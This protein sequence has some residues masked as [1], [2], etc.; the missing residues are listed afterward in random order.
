VFGTLNVY[1]KRKKRRGRRA[2]R[3]GGLYS[4]LLSQETLV[5][6]F[7]IGHLGGLRDFGNLSVPEKNVLS[8]TVGKGFAFGA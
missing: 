5:P 7:D 4:S 3:D 6:Y 8:A 1:E 2:G